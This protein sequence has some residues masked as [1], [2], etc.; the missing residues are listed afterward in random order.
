MTEITPIASSI[1]RMNG[2][3]FG[4]LCDCEALLM[5]DRPMLC[6]LQQIELTWM[7]LIF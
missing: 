4:G 3:S 7:A 2:L 5:I 6:D 1:F